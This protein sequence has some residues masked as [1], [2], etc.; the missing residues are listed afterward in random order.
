MPEREQHPL[1][2]RPDLTLE[3]QLQICRERTS[4]LWD[5]VWWMQLPWYRRLWYRL[6]RI[7]WDRTHRRPL[8][9]KGHRAPIRHFYE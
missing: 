8:F 5:Q 4:Q 6:P 3:Q 7:E 9:W 1:R 2:D